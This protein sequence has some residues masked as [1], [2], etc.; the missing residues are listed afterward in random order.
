MH[1]CSKQFGTRIQIPNWQTSR[2]LFVQ[3]YVPSRHAAL[4]SAF[5]GVAV[6]TASKVVKKSVDICMMVAGSDLARDDGRRGND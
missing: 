3:R 4:C 5:V 2:I 6:A 1:P